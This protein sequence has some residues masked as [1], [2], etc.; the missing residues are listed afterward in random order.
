MMLKEVQVPPSQGIGVVGF[1]AG[2]LA[3]RTHKNAAARKIEMDVQTPDRL[4][5]S[6]AIDHPWRH[7]SQGYLK[8]FVLIHAHA[9]IAQR[10]KSI[11]KKGVI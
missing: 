9:I 6:A 3:N 5:E 10:G 2:C 1:T 11:R 4:I 7:Q 8:Q